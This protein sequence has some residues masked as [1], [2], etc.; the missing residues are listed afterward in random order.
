MRKTIGACVNRQFKGILSRPQSLSFGLTV[1]GIVTRTMQI[2]HPSQRLVPAKW[3]F[4]SLAV[5]YT[6]PPV[7]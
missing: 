3:V 7:P 1:T 5:L 6:K 2:G 4:G